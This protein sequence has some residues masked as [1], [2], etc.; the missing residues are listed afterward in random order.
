MQWKAAGK[1][2]VFEVDV[3]RNQLGVELGEYGRVDN[4]KRRV[5][6]IAVDQINENTDITVTYNQ[7]KKGRVITGFSF[8]FRQKPIPKTIELDLT[9]DP[10]TLDMF[11]NLTDGQI[12]ALL[13]NGSFAGKY[14][15][16]GEDTPSYRKR[17]GRLLRTNPEQFDLKAF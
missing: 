6:D 7:H 1:T 10:N 17:V 14:A 9:R 12:D 13:S 15:E 3:F 16:I 11:T 5:L 8:S 2:P 4:F